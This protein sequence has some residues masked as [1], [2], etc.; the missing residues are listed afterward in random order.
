[1][2][3]LNLNE[4]QKIIKTYRLLC[5][6]P[7]SVLSKCFSHPSWRHWSFIIEHGLFMQKFHSA[8][9]CIGGIA[10]LVCYTSRRAGGF[11]FW[12]SWG[13]GSDRQQRRSV[14]CLRIRELIIWAGPGIQPAAKFN[15]TNLRN[16]GASNA[17]TGINDLLNAMVKSASLPRL[18]WRL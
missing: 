7:V 8:G 15:R 10:V 4:K 14:A 13:L 2:T 11:L 18:F 3:W 16:T 5:I 9:S 1:M 12:L 6:G 17:I